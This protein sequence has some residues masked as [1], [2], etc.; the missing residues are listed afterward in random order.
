MD[1]HLK[2]EQVQ[3]AADGELNL[4]RHVDECARCANAVL[5]ALRL[6]SVVRDAM[7]VEAAPVSLRKRVLPAKRAYAPWWIA[8]AAAILAVAISA[9]IV[10]HERSL[11]ARAELTD[12]HVTLL[13]GA[14]P[15][16]VMS[17]DRHTIKP[18]FEGRLPFA[19]PIPDFS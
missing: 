2:A 3:G 17:A 18:W 15:A 6:K 10:T 16:D 19:V 1:R 8:A 14:N 7:W 9:A 13:A 12:L 4:D 5:A 11:T